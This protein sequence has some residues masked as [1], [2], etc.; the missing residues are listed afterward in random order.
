MPSPESLV[1][2]VFTVV[3]CTVY[4]FGENEHPDLAGWKFR[5]VPKGWKRGRGAWCD[6]SV[7]G[8]LHDGIHEGVLLAERAKGGLVHVIAGRGP[9]PPALATHHGRAAQRRDLSHAESVE[10]DRALV[11]RR[12]QLELGPDPTEHLVQPAGVLGHLPRHAVH[13]PLPTDVDDA[14]VLMLVD[15]GDVPLDLALGLRVPVEL[16]PALGLEVEQRLPRRLDGLAAG[17][18]DLKL[19]SELGV[20]RGLD[21]HV[22]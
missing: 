3:L 14:E 13:E 4:L 7:P 19:G 12:Q 9:V 10:A 1:Y 6:P 22:H 21:P 18:V 17:L 15:L 11:L 2:V 8:H 5:K 20:V 16:G